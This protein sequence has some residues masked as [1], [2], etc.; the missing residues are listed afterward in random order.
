MD[1]VTKISAEAVPAT[2]TKLIINAMAMMC[3]LALVVFVLHGHERPRY[4]PRLFLIALQ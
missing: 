1:S 3:G 2:D 4:E